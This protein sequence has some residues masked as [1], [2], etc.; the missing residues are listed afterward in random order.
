MEIKQKSAIR[1][2]GVEYSAPETTLVTI[3]QTEALCGF[4]SQG[5]GTT[6]NYSEDDLDWE[7]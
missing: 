3:L 4:L 2:T 1:G 7:E 6:D 5:S